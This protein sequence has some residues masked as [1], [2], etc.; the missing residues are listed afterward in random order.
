MTSRISQPSHQANFLS[1]KI[2]II[3]AGHLGQ[4]LSKRLSLQKI[5]HLITKRS[6]A[7][8][9]LSSFQSFRTYDWYRDPFPKDCLSCQ[10]IVLTIP[11]SDPR[12]LP[13]AAEF[14]KKIKSSSLFLIYTSSIS[15]YGNS[16]PRTTEATTPSPESENGKKLWTLEQELGKSLANLCIL[17][18]GGLVSKERHPIQ[19]LQGKKN[20]PAGN[21]PI[22]LVHIDD[23]VTFL[24]QVIH[25]QL[26][27]TFNIVYP[28]HPIKS[29][30]YGQCAK[31][32]NLAPP[33]FLDQKFSRKIVD[34]EK[35]V[36]QS[37]QK[38]LCSQL[39]GT[40]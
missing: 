10:T 27:G 8:S 14:I 36:Q 11:P 15:V 4:K 24:N 22:N 29:E 13:A 40:R 25:L 39:D 38:Y 21:E 26:N 1:S 6:S 20:C 34:G 37:A 30:F 5:S 12:F 19:S 18:L 3:G 35:I 31:A 9:E 17:R 33:E 2:A 28:Y 32:W 23:V 16:G 7:P